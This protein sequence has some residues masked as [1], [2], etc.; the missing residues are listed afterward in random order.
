MSISAERKAAVIADNARADGDTGSD[1]RNA[2]LRR[3]E[4]E[5]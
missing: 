1:A 4:L 2:D 3:L 5:F